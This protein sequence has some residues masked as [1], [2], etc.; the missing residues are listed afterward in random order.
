MTEEKSAAS[1]DNQ[2]LADRGNNRSRQP[3]NSAFREFI[4]SNW[5]P[6][7]ENTQGR[8][9]S[10]PWAAARREALGKL[11]PNKRLVI[12][13][14]P[15]KVR[16]NDCDYRFRP[17]SAFAHLTGTGTDF[18][19]DAVLV[20]EPIHDGGQGPTHTA[21]LYFR[22]RAS[23]SSEEFYGDPRYGELWVGV[24]P[25]LEE[26]EHATGIA[27]AHID[28]LG[29]ALAK[30]AGTLEL[31]VVS[32]ADPSITELVNQVRSQNGAV[33]AQ[34]NA[35]N[36]AKLLEALAELRLIKD[37]W[38][39]EQLELAVSVTKSGFEKLR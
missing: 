4:G 11:F 34:V 12:P 5:G 25:S 38:E 15:L 24:R 37:Q 2:T 39:I 27:C 7:P 32:E 14:G 26:V 31:C 9:E 6:R 20:L 8:N 16:N 10:A 36:D 3:A 19:P 13:A 22:P 18:E 21:V 1:S 17:H 29:D 23:R 30:D 28:S 35:A 33:D